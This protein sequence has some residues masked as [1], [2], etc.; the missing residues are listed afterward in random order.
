MHHKYV[1]NQEEEFARS[2]KKLPAKVYLCVGGLEESTDSFMVSNMVRFGAILEGRKYK[3]LSLVS[4]IFANENHCEVVPLC[5][6]AGL[7][8]ALKK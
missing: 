2:H 7:K 1:F 8:M 4:K 3:G 5:F 6:Q